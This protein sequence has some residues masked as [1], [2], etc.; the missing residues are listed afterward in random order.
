LRA[1]RRLPRGLVEGGLGKVRPALDG[2]RKE[3]PR[4]ILRGEEVWV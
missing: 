4:R 1:V 3:L 2:L